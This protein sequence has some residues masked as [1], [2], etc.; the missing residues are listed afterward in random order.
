MIDA[1]MIRVYAPVRESVGADVV[2]R[3]EEASA[4]AGPAPIT[5]YLACSDDSAFV[6]RDRSR[7]AAR[8]ERA[9]SGLAHRTVIGE[10]ACN[11]A[12]MKIALDFDEDLY[13]RLKVEA[14][15]RGVS[16]RDLVIQVV[17]QILGPA[18]GTEADPAPDWAGSLRKFSPNAGGQYDLPA[19][20]ESIARGRPPKRK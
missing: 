17:R 2:V 11:I 9:V 5:V 1:A 6:H 10:T 13:R 20:R 19:V 7:A 14:A 12:R 8:E 3:T 16:I 15:R 4:T 18:P